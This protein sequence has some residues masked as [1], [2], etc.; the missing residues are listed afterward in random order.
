MALEREGPGSQLPTPHNAPTRRRLGMHAAP[1][2][3]PA[4]MPAP[5]PV[6]S[7]PSAFLDANTAKDAVFLPQIMTEVKP[8]DPANT[9]RRG[10]HGVSNWQIGR[11]AEIKGIKVRDFDRKDRWKAWRVRAKKIETKRA[12]RT[13]KGTKKTKGKKS[14][15]KV[16]L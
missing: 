14:N 9:T 5:A 7:I 3:T 1:I 2:S 4:P 10:G 11:A 15:K 8:F 13:A 16:V 6:E 12:A